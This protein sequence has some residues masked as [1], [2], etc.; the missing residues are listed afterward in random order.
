MAQIFI[1]YSKQDIEFARHLRTLLQN[2]GF[3]AW[4][5]ERLVPSTQWWR[6]LEG[7]IKSS[8]AF[9]VIMSP[10]AAE[11]RWVEREILVAE[12]ANLPIF[13]VLLAGEGWSRLADIQY[14]NLTAGLNATL[15]QR[16]I[17]GLRAVIDGTSTTSPLVRPIKNTP[18][19]TESRLLESAMPAET[20][21]GS[22]TEMWAKISLPDS[23]GLRSELPA[24]VPSGDVI[25]RGDA[26]TTS[27]PF[28]F[29]TDPQSGEKLPAQITMKASSADFIVRSPGGDDT[30]YIELPPDSDSRTIIF[31]LLPKPGGR[32]SGRARI[33]LDLIY[34][35]RV[36]AQISVSTQLVD[37]VS[38]SKEATPWGMWSVPVGSAS[39]GVSGYAAPSIAPGGVVLEQE[40]YAKEVEFAA[41]DVDLD[42]LPEPDEEVPEASVVD[43]LRGGIQ[44]EP[45][46]ETE[47][48]GE[49]W[50]GALPNAP[51]PPP[52]PVTRPTTR[53]RTEPEQQ[54]PAAKSRG[55]AISFPAVSAIAGLAFVFVIVFLL[56]NNSAQNTSMEGT[57]QAS[58]NM[59]LSVAT[60]TGAAEIE[61]TN[62]ADMGELATQTALADVPTATD[63]PS[64]TSTLVTPSERSGTAVTRLIGCATDDVALR[65]IDL[66]GEIGVTSEA[67]PSATD[68][69]AIAAHRGEMESGSHA[70]VIMGICEDGGQGQEVVIH[71]DILTPPEITGLLHPTEVE[72]RVPV[73]DMTDPDGSTA[74]FLL[75]ISQYLRGEFDANLLNRLS[76]VYD[77]IEDDPRNVSGVMELDLLL[78]IAHLLFENGYAPA[79]SRFQRVSPQA[80]DTTLMLNLA[81]AALNNAGAAEIAH[82]I[83]GDSGSDEFDE[84]VASA[85]AYLDQALNLT[86]D[87]QQRG[88]IQLN[89]DIL[90][91][92][93]QSSD[94]D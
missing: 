18:S 31:T 47:S 81:V 54:A 38:R 33:F 21:A 51:F 43:G 69:D 74:N 73:D 80:T 76:R 24:V 20:K 85:A 63:A 70:I 75:A 7:Q 34:E 78:G 13:P 62:L 22:D 41:A 91:S 44:N 23:P 5:D 83:A 12:N 40:E 84:A 48:P 77:A 15:P 28:R 16:F 71:A 4:L 59:A 42:A 46:A 65:L 3:D 56:M 67:L 30:E 60:E 49:D 94:E 87:D 88:V 2:A 36:I 35:S 11:S 66:V 52:A 57:L 26:R 8:T 32:T 1:S 29:P 72:F 9:I 64:G 68:D 79:L 25:Q 90:D 17:D 61:L 93:A 58:T 27:F 14:E 6:M 10:S 19:Q 92:L 39:A 50:R 53:A 55:R 82:A 37:V 86:Q 89:L 45:A